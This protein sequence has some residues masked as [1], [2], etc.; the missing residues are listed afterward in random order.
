MADDDTI[1]YN[2]YNLRPGYTT[3]IG[4][5]NTEDDMCDPLGYEPFE[6]QIIDL[7]TAG[8]NLAQY[9]KQQYPNGATPPDDIEEPIPYGLDYMEAID[10]QKSLTASLKKQYDDA[11]AAQAT[12]KTEGV[13]AAGGQPD[14]PTPQ[15]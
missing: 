15:A 1:V 14:T 13:S 7:F 4:E 5:T 11:Q 3:P 6:Q 9:Y 10:L 12:G 2:Q 8:A